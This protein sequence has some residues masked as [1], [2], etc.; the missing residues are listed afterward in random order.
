MF[1][2]YVT[3]RGAE[4]GSGLGLAVVRAIV[5]QIGGAI[6]VATAPRQGTTFTI[7]L[8]ARARLRRRGLR[9]SGAAIRI[10]H[11]TCCPAPGH[12]VARSRDESRY[13]RTHPA[14][15]PGLL[16]VE[17]AA[18]RHRDGRLHRA[19]ARPRGPRRPAR[20]GS[21]CT[22]ARRATS[23]TR[24]SRS[25]SCARDGD[26][27]A[28]TP[29]TDLFL[30]KRKP[31]YVGGILEMANHRLYP[32]LGPPHRRRCAPGCRRTRSSRRTRA[33]RGALRRP[34]PAARS[35]WRAMTGHQPRRQHDDRQRS[36]RG[37]TTGRFVDVGTAQ[38]D[39]AVQIAL[40]NPHLHGDRLRPAR[41]GADLRGLRGR[42]TA[43]RTA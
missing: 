28:N 23:S 11:R 8:P 3:T 38:G 7:D 16:G 14:D 2:P 9:G 32:L 12:P 30:D 37:R 18:E 36:S 15:R 5:D 20:A 43:S 35:S 41:G 34:G 42:R 4:Q 17:D 29:E 10:L 1:E 25:A 40:A 21:A 6:D 22:R 27:Y 33:L 26:V 31:S 19:G 24:W 13:P 39:L